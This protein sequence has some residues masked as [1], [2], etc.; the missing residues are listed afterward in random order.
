MTSIRDDF[1]YSFNKAGRHT[2]KVGGE[3]FHQS[4]YSYISRTSIGVLD[5]QGHSNIT[6]S[7]LLPNLKLDRDVGG[8]PL[9]S[10]VFNVDK[11]GAKFDFGDLVVER[12]ET[13]KQFVTFDLAVN[14]VHFYC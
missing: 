6:F 4:V 12:V 13:P 10:V 11:L 14:V 5:A 3:Y 9:V 8:Q 7:R 2:L 1:T